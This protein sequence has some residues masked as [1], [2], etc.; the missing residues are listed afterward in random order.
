MKVVDFESV[1]ALTVALEGQDE[2]I[3]ATSVPDPS[4]AIRLID[5]AAA[6]N[7]H[8]MIPAEFSGDPNNTRT[9]GLP[10]FVGKAKVFEHLQKLAKTT[11]LTWT[12]I[13]NNA[14]LD[15]GLRNAFLGIDIHQKSIEYFNDGN[16]TVPYTTLASVGTAV[17]NALKKSGETK[18]R[19]CYICNAQMTQRELVD[20]VQRALGEEGW[21]KR[22]LDMNVVLQRGM[23][24]IQAGRITYEVIRDIIRFS[25]ATPGYTRSLEQTD[26]E[27]L[28][29][30]LMDDRQIEDLMKQIAKE[31]THI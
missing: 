19:I 14:F 1:S 6:A 17:S 9:R 21:Q 12:I 28:G 23:G 11:S 7:V 27:L 22:N 16:V 4:F 25:I 30:K 31:I 15:W 10:A 20:S 24:E 18:N 26:N 8:R 13:S 29:V 5:A 3:D 2:L